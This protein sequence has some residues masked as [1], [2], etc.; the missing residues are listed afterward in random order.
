[1]YR[2]RKVPIL[3]PPILTHSLVL[4]STKGRPCSPRLEA[5]L[6]SLDDSLFSSSMLSLY[7][8]YTTIPIPSS[9]ASQTSNG[10]RPTPLH[11]CT[12]TAPRMQDRIFAIGGTTST[13]SPYHMSPPSAARALVCSCS[14]LTASPALVSLVLLLS[15]CF[16]SL[17]SHVCA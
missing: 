16:S 1:M 5:P 11:H 17:T 14:W 7:H 10:T 13:S 9:M 8:V 6:G 3:H 12:R 4:T 15:I 2:A